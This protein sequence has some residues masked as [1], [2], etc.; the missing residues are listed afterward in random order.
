M[1][2]EFRGPRLEVNSDGLFVSDQMQGAQIWSTINAG[3][4]RISSELDRIEKF[5][6]TSAV[7]NLPNDGPQSSER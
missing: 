4:K 5:Y 2:N 3:L 6:D 7:L 1:A